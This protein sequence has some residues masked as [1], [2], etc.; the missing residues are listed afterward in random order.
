MTLSR[1][2]RLIP[3]KRFPNF[4]FLVLGRNAVQNTD[5]CMLTLKITCMLI[6]LIRLTFRRRIMDPMILM[7][8]AVGALFLI[9]SFADLISHVIGTLPF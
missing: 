1:M 6:K 5:S 3:K 9:G 2:K 4:I 8:G 7:L